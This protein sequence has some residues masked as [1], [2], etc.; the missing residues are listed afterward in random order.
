MAA[1]LDPDPVFDAEDPADLL[2][3]VPALWPPRAIGDPLDAGDPRD[4]GWFATGA[5]GQSGR[6]DAGGYPG[7]RSDQPLSIVVEIGETLD[8]GGPL[9]R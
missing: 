4:L 6:H 7:G 2:P 5:L 8:A 3:E 1:R 9:N